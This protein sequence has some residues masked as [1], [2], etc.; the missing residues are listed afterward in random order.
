MKSYN[1]RTPG[2][3]IVITQFIT[4]L[5]GC[6]LLSGKKRDGHKWLQKLLDFIVNRSGIAETLGID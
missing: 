1:T 2:S 5:C 4:Q 3:S 6:Y